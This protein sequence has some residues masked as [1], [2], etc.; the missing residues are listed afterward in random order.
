MKPLVRALLLEGMT[1]V[2]LH[3]FA[4]PDLLCGTKW[5]LVDW[6]LMNKCINE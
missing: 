5:A 4:G 3:L 2:I 6:L 1:L